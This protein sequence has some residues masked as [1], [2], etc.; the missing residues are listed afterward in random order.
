[1]LLQMKMK[2]RS[3]RQRTFI[4]K[5]HL[6]SLL[7]FQ[8]PPTKNSHQLQSVE[9]LITLTS[10]VDLNDVNAVVDVVHGKRGDDDGYNW[11]HCIGRLAAEV[12]KPS[13]F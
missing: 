9:T 13:R 1:M 5:K 4:Y 2:E 3:G 12:H 10:D 11:W 8:T 7:Q 6:N